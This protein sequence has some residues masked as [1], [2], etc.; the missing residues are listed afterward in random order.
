MKAEKYSGKCVIESKPMAQLRSL[1]AKELIEEA[2]KAV[3]TAARAKRE[4]ADFKATVPAFAKVVAAL[5]AKFN[6]EAAS[7]TSLVSTMTFE[8]YFTEMTAGKITTHVQ[9]VA[10]A[11]GAYV[12]NGLITEADYDKCAADWLEKAASI[13]T[14]AQL[15]L[16]SEHVMAAAA[17]L[18][19]RPKDGAKQLQNILAKISGPKEISEEKAREYLALIFSNGYINL[20]LA[21]TAAEIVDPRNA[22]KRNH[23]I[24]HL[25]AMMQSMT[26]A[27]A[28]P[29][30]EKPKVMSPEIWANE[31]LGGLIDAR[32]LPG[33]I[34]DVK[35]Y[36]EANSG[37]YPANADTWMD[38]CEQ[39][40]NLAETS[41]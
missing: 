34:E 6:A 31:N 39:R 18:K 40:A 37:Q 28:K 3:S 25:A 11:F 21:S 1:T 24:G 41:Q 20:L 7:G 9:S 4:N 26:G 35:A 32:E 8:R 33:A 19:D 23:I 22:D 38:W 10:K 15:D 2:K 5:T 36:V 30:D 16:K 12:D 27:P 17:I 29:R 13:V 14:A